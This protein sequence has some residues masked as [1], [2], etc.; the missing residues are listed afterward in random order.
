MAAF[1]NNLPCHLVCL[2]IQFEA[3]FIHSSCVAERSDEDETRMA[4]GRRAA[5]ERERE[6]NKVNFDIM[7]N[8]FSGDND[9]R[10]ENV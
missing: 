4:R 7:K 9:D 5:R 2:A 8:A 6:T 1:G 3:L 10:N